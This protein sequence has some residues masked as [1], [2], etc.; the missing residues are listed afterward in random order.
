MVY[1]KHK[2]VKDLTLSEAAIIA[3]MF[4]SPSY[5]APIRNPKNATLRRSQVLYLM[6]RH[7]YITAAERKAANEIPVESLTSSGSEAADE[8]QGYIDTVAE[9]LMR[10]YKVD[11]YTTPLL[12]YTNMDRS[13]QDGV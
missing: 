2:D 9:E 3:G 6:E 1:K 5:Y 8:Y 13:K 4:K 12:V 10:L 7:G 11:P